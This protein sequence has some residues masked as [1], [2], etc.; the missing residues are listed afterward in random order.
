M[1]SC[2]LSGRALGRLERPML[3]AINRQAC[4]PVSDPVYCVIHRRL[5]R[6][7]P[8]LARL[9]GRRIRALV[10]IRQKVEEPAAQAG[11]RLRLPAEVPDQLCARDCSDSKARQL[12]HQRH[13]GTET[14]DGAATQKYVRERQRPVPPCCP[15]LANIVILRR[16]KKLKPKGLQSPV[17]FTGGGHWLGILSCRLGLRGR[18]DFS[19]RSS[20]RSGSFF[21]ISLHENSFMRNVSPS[22]SRGCGGP[23]PCPARSV[24]DDT[25]FQ[26]FDLAPWPPAASRHQSHR[27][28]PPI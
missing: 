19:F 24:A 10:Q 6:E 23:R 28:P 14:C 25:M 18:Y 16:A 12:A 17:G 11:M 20:S 15:V 3:I 8:H 2:A 7:D 5:V 1:T 27:P 26:A 13:L 9:N 21:G 22:A 4:A